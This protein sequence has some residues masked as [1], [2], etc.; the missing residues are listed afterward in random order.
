MRTCGFFGALLYFGWLLWGSCILK[1]LFRVC[2]KAW[3]ELGRWEWYFGAT[4]TTRGEAMEST[5]QS[6]LVCVCMIPR[7]QV[8]WW[9][10]P[11]AFV[12]LRNST[13]SSFLKD[14]FSGYSNFSWQ[15]YILLLECII[16][17]FPGIKVFTEKFVDRLMG[18]LLY[19]PSHFSLD[20]FK[21]L[22]VFNF[23]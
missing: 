11:S 22:F 18:I 9:W 16:P 3:E 20:A 13:S 23:W 4:K 2:D 8:W 7:R 21:I 14:S 17:L 10:T 19:V 5:F 15:F 12:H 6:R 1:C